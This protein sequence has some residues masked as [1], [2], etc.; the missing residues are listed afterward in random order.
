MK[1]L[2]C[3]CKLMERRMSRWM[4]DWM[5]GQQ[6]PYNFFN[7]HFGVKKQEIF[8]QNYL[9]FGQAMEKIFRQ[10]TSAPLNKTGPVRL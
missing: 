7:C 6:P 2:M 4:E 3:G 8:G 9:I 10:K 1:R 5:D